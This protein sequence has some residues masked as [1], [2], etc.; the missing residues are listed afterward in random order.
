MSSVRT[1]AKNILEASSFQVDNLEG[2]VTLATGEFV[3]DLMR[4]IGEQL[5]ALERVVSWRES[6]VLEHHG[7]AKKNAKKFT[8]VDFKRAMDE[9]DHSTCPLN[10]FDEA[11]QVTKKGCPI[12]VENFKKANNV[13]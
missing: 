8:L 4:S 12:A 11:T 1:I 6:L 2:L 13:A 10:S 9:F 7:V 3:N 5:K